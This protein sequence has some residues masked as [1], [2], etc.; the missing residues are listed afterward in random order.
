MKLIEPTAEYAEEIRAYRQAFLD[1]GDSMDGTGGLEQ[2]DDPLEWLGYLA[3][4]RD[5]KTVPEGRVPATQLIFVRETDGRIVGMLDIRHCLSEYLAKFGGH[6]GYSV[7]PGERRRGYAT[8]MLKAALPVC[9]ELGIGRVLITCAKGNEGSR[10]TILNNGGVYETTVFEP[11]EKID[12]E[13][14]WIT[15]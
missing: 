2:F 15:L 13:K 7:A 11:D 5:P 14:Y 6:I 4:H 10:R 3:K 1:S 9:R 8:Q 12:L